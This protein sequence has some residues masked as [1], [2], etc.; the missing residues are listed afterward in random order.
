M[1]SGRLLGL[2]GPFFTEALE[3]PYK[4][5]DPRQRSLRLSIRHLGSPF[6]RTGRKSPLK[7]PISGGVEFSLLFGIFRPRFPEPLETPAKWPIGEDVDLSL[8][9]G[10]FD[11]RFPESIEALSKMA[12][13]R[14]RRFVFY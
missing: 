11:P 4:M 3:T 13:A 14:R 6:S 8:L 5:A 2:F 10:L 9:L 1:V 12:D 7:W